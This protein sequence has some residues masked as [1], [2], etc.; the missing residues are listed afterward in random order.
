MASS[1]AT[2]S[3]PPPPP[4]LSAEITASNDDL[5]TEILLRLPIKSLIKFKSVSKYWL[6]LISSPEFSLRR[7]ARLASATGLFLESS[8]SDIPEFDFIDLNNPS[9]QQSTPPFRSL[10]FAN[11]PSTSAGAARIL[12]SCNGLLLCCNTASSASE[13]AETFYYV[14]NPT[15][16]QYARL[17]RLPSHADHAPGAASATIYGMALAFDPSKSPHYKVICVTNPTSDPGQF[18]IDIYSSSSGAWRPPLLGPFAAGFSTL[19]H[20]GVFWDGAVHWISPWGPS[21]R[22]DVDEERMREMP[23][24]PVPH[25]LEG[26]DRMFGYFGESRGRLHFVDN[27]LEPGKSRLNVYE[28]E[29][30]CS[31]WFVK[32]TVDLSELSAVFPEMILSSEPDAEPSPDEYHFSVFC[33]VRGEVEEDSYLV[34][35]IPEKILRYN[36]KSRTFC[37][38][39]DVPIED[40]SMM[41]LELPCAYQY[42]ESL[43]CV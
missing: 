31:G 2:T 37:K 34:V 6:S 5:L 24:P 8:K 16:K 36:F 10:A 23:M 27:V 32:Y 25:A 41:V 11:S 4:P 1:A 26:I 3:N 35:N 14:Y 33:V 20:N 30:D 19:F 38:L 12:Q 42:I 40:V 7:S 21:L 22:F 15:N 28:M 13:A 17:P 9:P 43:A 29:R 39:C 18:C